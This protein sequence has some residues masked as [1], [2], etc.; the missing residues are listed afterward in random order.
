[1]GV[2]RTDGMGRRRDT[3]LVRAYPASWRARYE[4]EMLSVLAARPP[5]LRDALDLLRGALDAH[6]HPVAPSR[7]PA[8][9]ALLSGASWTVVALA[10]LLE[11]VPPDW[12]GYLA[13]ILPVALVGTVAGLVAAFGVALRRGDGAGPV[14]WGATALLIAGYL[15]WAAAL[16]VAVAGGPYGALTAAGSTA[17][18]AGT[19][20]TGGMLLRA[21]QPVV[22]VGLVVIAGAL[23]LPPPA[24]WVALAAA[25]T[26][27]ACWL[28]AERAGIVVARP[29][30]GASS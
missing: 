29:G 2:G 14:T 19:L 21:R 1:M 5:G 16:A 28:V 26:T 25:W 23:V 24:A 13:W 18:A 22:G 20:A 11:P 15:A 7:V 4:V 3:W 9:A 17:A 8:H 10:V 30:P 6:L 27:L 12:P